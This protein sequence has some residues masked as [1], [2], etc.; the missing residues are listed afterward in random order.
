[1]LDY[2]F[3][4]RKGILFIRLKGDADKKADNFF[5]DEIDPL[6]LDNGIENVVLN[7]S[8][9]NRVDYDGMLAIYNSYLRLSKKSN[10]FLCEIPSY[11]KDKFKYLFDNINEKEDELTILM[12]N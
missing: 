7:V 9:L 1:M 12:K 10:V 3:V 4:F 8:K 6:I 5:A 2:D 11:L